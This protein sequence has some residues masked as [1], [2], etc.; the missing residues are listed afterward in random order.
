MSPLSDL[1]F[2]NLDALTVGV[3]VL[4]LTG[5]SLWRHIRAELKPRECVFCGGVF[6][7]DEYA[8]HVESCALKKMLAQ[9]GHEWR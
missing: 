4:L 8:R 3:G 7:P 2:S 9:R 1:S 6:A 5:A